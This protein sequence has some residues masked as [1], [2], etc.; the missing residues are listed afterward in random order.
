MSKAKLYLGR[1]GQ[2][3]VMSEFLDRGYNVAVPE[4]DAGDHIF[5]VKD[6]S[7]E[8]TRIQVKT[9]RS[10]TTNHGAITQYNV[11][12]SQL[13]LPIVPEIWYIFVQ[14]VANK[15]CDYIIISREQ[16]FEYYEN[17]GIGSPS[18]GK[19]NLPI[20]HKDNQVI[21]SGINLTKHVN[22]WSKWPSLI[23]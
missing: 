23:L 16:L 3:V 2:M 9:S 1:A 14:R 13:K 20:K 19:L 5:V 17:E 22:D 4:V 11:R 18:N 12:L 15:W 6:D 8:F 7:G 10:K 21:C